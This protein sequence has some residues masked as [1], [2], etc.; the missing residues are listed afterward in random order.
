MAS[1]LV[2]RDEARRE[3]FEARDYY[4]EQRPGYGERFVEAVEAEFELLLQYPKI[5]RSVRTSVRRRTISRRPYG[6]VYTIRGE[7]LVIIA[8]AHLGDDLSIG[9]L[10]FAETKRPPSAGG[11]SA[12]IRLDTAYFDETAAGVVALI[13]AFIGTVMIGL[14][15]SFV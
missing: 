3:L 6:I 12:E 15:L 1:V 9:V 4:D 8:I 10:D 14:I 13:V 11:L 5:G 2:V 7:E